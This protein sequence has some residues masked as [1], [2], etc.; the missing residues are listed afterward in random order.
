MAVSWQYRVDVSYQFCY[1]GVSKRYKDNSNPYNVQRSNHPHLEKLFAS[2]VSLDH[3]VTLKLILD[4]DD[5]ALDNPGKYSKAQSFSPDII[6]LYGANA[7]QS[8]LVHPA[9]WRGFT[10]MPIVGG[11]DNNVY[12]RGHGSGGPHLA[13]LR[14]VP[15]ELILWPQVWSDVKPV[16]SSPVVITGGDTKGPYASDGPVQFR[17]SHTTGNTYSLV[18]NVFKYHPGDENKNLQDY[19]P[20]P[21]FN[22]KRSN[23][24]DFLSFLS[25]N[26]NHTFYNVVVADPTLKHVST[27]TRLRMFGQSSTSVTFRL[28]WHKGTPVPDKLEVS[29]HD[30]LGKIAIP[31]TKWSDLKE[32]PVQLEPSYDGMLTLHVFTS[33]DKNTF[34]DPY[35]GLSLQVLKSRGRRGSGP[36]PDLAEAAIDPLRLHTAQL[37]GALNVIFEPHST[38][39]LRFASPAAVQLREHSKNCPGKDDPNSGQDCGPIPVT[40]PAATGWWFRA[41][42][43]DTNNFPLTGTGGYSPDIQP[44]GTDLTKQ[45][46]WGG[47][48]NPDVDYTTANS[49]QLIEGDTNYIFVRGHS[50]LADIDLQCRLIEVP[51]SALLHPSQ[52]MKNGISAQVIGGTAQIDQQSLPPVAN[53]NQFYLFNKPFDLTTPTDPNTHYCLVAEVRQKRKC[54]LMYSCWPNEQQQDFA[55]LADFQNWIFS[56]P[57]V[58]WRNINWIPCTPG[59]QCTQWP[60]CTQLVIPECASTCTFWTIIVECDNAIIP[61]GSTWTLTCENDKI[62]TNGV[63][64][65]VAGCHF[66]G[67]PPG[68]TAK[69]TLY[70]KWCHGG[71]KIPPPCVKFRLAATE[72]LTSPIKH[73]TR[74]TAPGSEKWPFHVTK[75]YPYIGNEPN[76]S[77]LPTFPSSGTGNIWPYP[78]V[79]QF[80]LGQDVLYAK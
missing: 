62:F 67:A 43:T 49:V 41:H 33:K 17:P 19:E 78:G 48:Q 73:L 40:S 58:C 64:F 54:C 35:S 53:G 71:K 5:D 16:S 45:G 56:C 30:N 23:V 68:Y 76:P 52:Y 18:A 31:R 11:D 39:N 3:A 1:V 34:F 63:C 36:S 69:L 22:F 9:S 15:S 57:L 50:T 61:A 6:P 32:L 59:P 10:G 38:R 46:L 55:T 75:K 60:C 24:D 2:P 13:T 14:A 20:A 80:T 44:V 21:S 29:L 37:L 28:N 66:T 51:G 42:V 70:V 77:P 79:P 7:D 27:T 47:L 26:K 65:D 74:D 12:I 72:T 25:E 8:T 4:P